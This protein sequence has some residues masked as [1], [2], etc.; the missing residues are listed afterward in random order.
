MGFGLSRGQI[1]ITAAPIY[2]VPSGVTGHAKSI[3]I[4]NTGA[5]TENVTIYLV[6]N[7]GG[8]VGT[9]TAADI[10][11]VIVLDPN[12]SYELSSDYSINA[13]AENDTI[14]ASTDTATTV[15]YF[16]FGREMT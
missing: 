5:G 11:D 6:D 13:N 10:V 3:M 7:S 8:S 14:Q 15:N 9:A 16:V 4:H 2:T 1:G 12:K